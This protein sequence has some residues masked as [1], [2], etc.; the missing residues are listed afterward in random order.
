MQGHETEGGFRFHGQRLQT[1]SS[2][3]LDF[4]TVTIEGTVEALE[5]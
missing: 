5:P 2:V 4:G 3:V 1:G